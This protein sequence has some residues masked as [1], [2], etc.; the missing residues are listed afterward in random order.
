[1]AKKIK[2]SFK[3][4][5]IQ[6]LS[7]Q[8]I[9]QIP[10]YPTEWPV[11]SML[12]IGATSRELEGHK[13]GGNFKTVGTHAS[14]QKPERTVVGKRSARSPLYVKNKPRGTARKLVASM[15]LQNYMSM[16][17]CINRCKLNAAFLDH[18]QESRL[19]KNNEAKTSEAERLS[20]IIIYY[21]DISKFSGGHI[22]ILKVSK[23][24]PKLR[25][26]LSSPKKVNENRE[27]T[28]I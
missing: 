14:L 11:D 18:A 15:T 27:L 9:L 5:E 17:K 10:K 6:N 24:S 25:K 1:M 19:F 16:R 4:E 12:E 13:M 21:A 22:K 23:K 26:S 7:N 3:K 20:K 2:P 28:L 8:L